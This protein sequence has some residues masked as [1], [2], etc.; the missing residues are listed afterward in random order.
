V[1]LLGGRLPAVRSDRIVESA[2][3]RLDVIG[4][5]WRAL[6]TVA[7]DPWRVTSVDEVTPAASPAGGP[8]E[9]PHRVGSGNDPD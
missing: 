7:P 3:G 9:R 5:G 1:R 4:P 6:V 8:A 2:D